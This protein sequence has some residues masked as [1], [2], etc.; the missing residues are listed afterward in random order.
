M[1]R[2]A[3][4]LEIADLTQFPVTPCLEFIIEQ[5]SG[6]ADLRGR[7]AF[8]AELAHH[9]LDLAGRDALDVHLVAR[10]KG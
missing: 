6:T 2:F 7:D 3:V 10:E 1:W 8:D 9:R 4:L 5:S